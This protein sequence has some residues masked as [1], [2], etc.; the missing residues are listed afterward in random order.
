MKLTVFLSGHLRAL[1]PDRPKAC[2][3]RL[4]K[5]LTV[6]ELANHLGISPWLTM[7]ANVNGQ[8][9]RHDYL[10]KED[11]VVVT[12]IGPMGGG[13]KAPGNVDG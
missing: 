2:V 3:V 1:Y 4:E 10:F 5:R 6:S 8:L 13:M 12:L 7:S 11:D 9:K